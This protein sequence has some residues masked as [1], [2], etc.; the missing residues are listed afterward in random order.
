LFSFGI[1]WDKEETINIGS[2]SGYIPDVKCRVQPASLDLD[3]GLHCP[4]QKK[5]PVE[6]FSTL[7]C[8]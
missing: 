8:K 5:A 3:V 7:I 4:L 1:F 6:G 2:G